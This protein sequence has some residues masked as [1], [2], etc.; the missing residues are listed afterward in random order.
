MVLDVVLEGISTMFCYVQKTVP[1]FAGKCQIQRGITCS[2]LEQVS[3]L[4]W[5]HHAT[6]GARNQHQLN[7]SLNVPKTS[8]FVGV[9]HIFQCGY[10]AAFHQV[11]SKHAD[12]A[13]RFFVHCHWKQLSSSLP[14]SSA[15]N[16]VPICNTWLSLLFH[17]SVGFSAYLQEA[18]WN[19]RQ[20]IS[21]PLAFRLHWF[22]LESFTFLLIK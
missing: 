2:G 11:T 8:S 16:S 20:L 17:W 3:V 6:G 22:F 12:F 21:I 14:K 7:N 13:A 9:S 18:P 4:L 5:A 19:C 1:N 15:C 10:F